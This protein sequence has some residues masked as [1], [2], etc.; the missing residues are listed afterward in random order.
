MS[1]KACLATI[2]SYLLLS[3]S[4]AHA[5][6]VSSFPMV[7]QGTLQAAFSPWDNVEGLIVDAI[8]GAKKQV[9]VQAYL[10]TSKKIAA[11]LITAQRRGIGV[12]VLADADQVSRDESSKVPDL[13]AAG[14]PVWLETRYQNAHN[15]VIL[16]DPS[17]AA[18]IVITGS[19]NFTWSAQHKN[20]ENILIA[21]QNPSLALRYLANW[22]R[23]QQ[24]AIL[25]QK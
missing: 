23:H 9:L 19:Y 2:F 20:A 14:I 15:K 17:T 18:A 24:E 13:V 25:Y 12:K 6:D 21:R 8:D 3:A 10:L 5:F 11:S 4:L 1:R 16:I 22:E 7:A